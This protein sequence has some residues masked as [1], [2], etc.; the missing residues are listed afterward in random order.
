MQS[1]GA[2]GNLTGKTNVWGTCSISG[3]RTSG[4]KKEDKE[5]EG[6]PGRGKL[7]VSQRGRVEVFLMVIPL[8]F[9][10]RS[11]KSV[12]GHSVKVPPSL[13]T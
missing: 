13:Y 11:S 10:H 4:R 7:R 2:L 8:L 3:N 5:P 12:A 1:P 9:R 6:N